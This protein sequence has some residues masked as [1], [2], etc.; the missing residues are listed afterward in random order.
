MERVLW[1][2]QMTLDA[3]RLRFDGK[4]NREVAAILGV[5]FNSVKA[6]FRRLSQ[7]GAGREKI[8]DETPESMARYLRH[9]ESLPKD[10]TKEENQKLRRLFAAGLSNIEIA[11]Q[12]PGR[13][14]NAVESR[15][16]RLGLVRD[17]PKTDAGMPWYEPDRPTETR[18]Y[19]GCRI[20]VTGDCG[21]ATRAFTARLM[22]CVGYFGKR[23]A[24]AKLGAA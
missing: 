23:R 16:A 6:R 11:N 22:A 13:T 14:D 9:V 15:I 10:W 21:D 18:T 24:A 8:W 5:G 7:P 12:M 1:S 20:S 17:A 3:M 2:D 19:A 4:T